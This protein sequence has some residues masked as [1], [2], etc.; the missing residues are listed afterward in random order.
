M[1]HS[2]NRLSK[3][4][5]AASVS[6][7][8][9]L[10][11]VRSQGLPFTLGSCAPVS[12]AAFSSLPLSSPPAPL[13]VLDSAGAMWERARTEAVSRDSEGEALSIY[14]SHG[15]VHLVPPQLTTLVEAIL[16]R[17]AIIPDSRSSIESNAHRV[18]G[19]RDLCF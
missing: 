19:Q 4:G 3:R 8:C 10:P 12:T 15:R 9:F 1:P 5:F 16:V 6:L 14:S 17:E 18:D 7:F 11:S 13:S 2:P